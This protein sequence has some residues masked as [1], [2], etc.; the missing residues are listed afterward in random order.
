MGVQDCWVRDL[1]LVNADNGVLVHKCDRLTVTGLNLTMTASREG[2]EP[3]WDGHWG[4]RTAFSTDILLDGFTIAPHMFH[5]VGADGH[6]MYCVFANGSATDGNLELHRWV[7]GVGWGWVGGC[8][9]GPMLGSSY[10]EALTHA[11]MVSALPSACSPPHCARLLRCRAQ[12][13]QILFTD[14]D[15]GASSDG[16]H[17]GGPQTSGPNSGAWT[18]FWNIR[19]TNGTHPLPNHNGGEPG[20]CTFGPDLNF[21]G[22]SFAN[23]SGL[24][25]DW[26]YQPGSVEPPNLFQAQLERRR[27]EQQQAEE[28]QQGG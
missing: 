21:I 27:R 2:M 3:T 5:T 11:C 23:D 7:G 6:S 8:G 9:Q 4:M 18:T 22:V 13:A 1:G 25:P 28:D 24:C 20:A 17:S 10:V 15:L 12:A 26:V 14:I 19:A 16:F